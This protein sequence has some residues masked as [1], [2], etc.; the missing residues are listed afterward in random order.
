MKM[1]NVFNR[2]ELAR[3]YNE[4]EE[5]LY[6][7][8]FSADCFHHVI[9]RSRKYT[10]SILNATPLCNHSCHLPIHGEHMRRENQERFIVL[11]AKRLYREGYK[12]KQLD[13][14]FIAEHN[15]A[16]IIIYEI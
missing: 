7:L 13:L 12:L 2:E 9:S 15:L 6:C 14:D 1:S 11:N 10:G 4:I 16:G 3:Y 5:C 8:K